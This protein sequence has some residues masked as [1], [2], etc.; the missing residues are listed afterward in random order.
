MNDIIINIINELIKCY[1]TELRK[2]DMKKRKRHMELNNSHF[3]L[4]FVPLESAAEWRIFMKR[5]FATLL[6]F[7][8]LTAL[9]GCTSSSTTSTSSVSQ[10][11]TSSDCECQ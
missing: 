8:M 11:E 5:F 2:E 7:S 9:A 4:L 1:I 10:K 3:T 6:A